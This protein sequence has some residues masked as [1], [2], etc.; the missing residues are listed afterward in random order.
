MAGREGESERK[1]DRDRERDTQ[2][3]RDRERDRDVDKN[4]EKHQSSYIYILLSFTSL[5]DRNPHLRIHYIIILFKQ[6]SYIY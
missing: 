5:I 4:I 6:V 3:D 2:R 1:R